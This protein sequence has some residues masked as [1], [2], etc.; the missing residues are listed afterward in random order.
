MTTT[1]TM[2]KSRRSR[3]PGLMPEPALPE[4][5][6]DDFSIP[7]AFKTPMSPRPTMASLD[8]KMTLAQAVR[9]LLRTP[10]GSAADGR[11]LEQLAREVSGPHDFLAIGP[12]GELTKVDPEKTTLGDISVP[13]EVR[14]PRGVEKVRIAGFEVQAYAPVGTLSDGEPA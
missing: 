8:R 13:R 2:T 10:P 7:V 4:T 9:E 1:M 12:E 11:L 14:T 6:V 5:I 3:R